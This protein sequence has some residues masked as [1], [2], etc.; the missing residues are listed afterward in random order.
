MGYLDGKWAPLIMITVINTI[1]GMVNA[2]I[3]KVLDGGINHMVI[4]TY[5]LGISTLFLLPI[6]YFWERKTRPKLTTSISCQHFFSALFGA[7][8]MQFFFLLGLS[9]TS[10]TLATAFWGT[11]PALTFIMALIF[12]FEKLNMKTKIGYGVI[13]GAMISLAGALTL[14]MYQGIPLSNSH[15]QATISSIHKGNENWI[16][17]CFLL[18]TGV[19]LFSSWMLIQAKI[20]VSYPCPYSS[21]VILSV[22]GTLQCT[23]LSFIKTRHV[24]DWILGDKLTIFT[25]II[26]GVIGQGMCTVGISW[27]IKQRGPVF[28]AAFS[29]VTLMSATVFDFVI[30]HRMI[31]VGSVIG[32]VVVVIGLY[33]FLWSKSKHIDECKIVTLPTN[34]VEKE[35]EEEDHTNVN[36]LGRILVIPM[37]P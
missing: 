13:L 10:A 5:R 6:A 18:F 19:I 4:A 28:T 25:V 15:E 24:E 37:T 34:T 26:A 31:Y 30:L 22:F 36:K 7:S 29:P 17:G 16:K 21:T 20:N 12:G 1:N 35:K 3:K 27:C 11:L 23:I 32:S 8:L 14:T 33:I 2:L 9:Y